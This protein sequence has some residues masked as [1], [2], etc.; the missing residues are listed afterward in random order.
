MQHI[1]ENLK[2]RKKY[3]DKL[4][5]QYKNFSLIQFDE[6]HFNSSSSITL[7][8]YPNCF[9]HYSHYNWPR[10]TNVVFRDEE[11]H[12]YDKWLQL[13]YNFFNAPSHHSIANKGSKEELKQILNKN[14]FPIT[15]LVERI[16]DLPK[17]TL[18]QKKYFLYDDSNIIEHAYYAELNRKVQTYGLISTTPIGIRST[19]MV[20]PK[21]T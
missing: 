17:L 18:E 19:H 15:E 6:W 10:Y 20:T 11:D 13:S 9:H 1:S 3:L 2:Y 4:R 21:K 7:Y 14:V 5:K 12:I 16:G 8:Y